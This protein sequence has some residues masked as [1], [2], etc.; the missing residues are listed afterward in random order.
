MTEVE[1]VAVGRAA[2]IIRLH[3]GIIGHLR[4]S[5]MDAIHIGQLLTEQK[6]ELAYGAWLPWVS[7]Q[8]PFSHD[9]ATRYMKL[10]EHA[11]ELRNVR[12][13]HGA[14][15]AIRLLAEGKQPH[16]SSSTDKCNTPQDIIDRVLLV[17]G[18][19][20][21]D[22]CSDDAEHPNV[23]ATL[24]F[25]EADDGLSG[26]WYG[27]VYMNPPYGT[28]LPHWIEKLCGEF[29]AGRVKEAIALVPSRTDT[30]WFRRLRDFPRC[31]IQGRLKFGDAENSAPFP[32]MAVYLGENVPGFHCAFAGLGDIYCRSLSGSPNQ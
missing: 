18:T 15:Q 19:I 24:H 17:L 30:Q 6:G 22:P 1:I 25:T 27:R 21:L 10:Y 2:E 11:A 7:Q 4:T 14:Y 5:V 8:L 28:A 20:D 13:L 26:S 31:F 16:F 3:E 29:E 32:S 23:P 9:T 12:N